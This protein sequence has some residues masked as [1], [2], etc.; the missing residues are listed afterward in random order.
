MN[1]HSPSLCKK[2]LRELLRAIASDQVPLRPYRSEPR[3]VKRRPK[4]YQL[5]TRPR[6]EMVVSKS[7]RVK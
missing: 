1:A 5:L 3:A 7:R 6:H 2:Q 4:S